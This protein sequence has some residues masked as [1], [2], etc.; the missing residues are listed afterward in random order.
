MED[1]WN[2]RMEV[3]SVIRHREDQVMLSHIPRCKP[4]QGS[5]KC[6]S[7]AYTPTCPLLDSIIDTIRQAGGIPTDEIKGF[8]SV[9]EMDEF[10]LEHL[11]YTQLAYI[12]EDLDNDSTDFSSNFLRYTIVVNST[13]WQCIEME[14]DTCQLDV[15]NGIYS[16][17]KTVMDEHLIHRRTGKSVSLVSRLK[18]TVHPQL[19][20]LDLYAS[21][22]RMMTF[23][24]Y[25]IYSLTILGTLISDKETGIKMYLRLFTMRD[26]PHWIS[27][28]VSSMLA[29]T[30]LTITNFIMN[31][32]FDI[33]MFTKT[34][35][36]ILGIHFFLVSL[37]VST[38][39]FF[40]SVF[41]K[42]TRGGVISGFAVVMLSYI[43]DAIA[44]HLFIDGVD[45]WIRVMFTFYPTVP[46]EHGLYIMATLAADASRDS[47]ITWSE[48][49]DTYSI[50][51]YSLADDWFFILRNSAIFMFLTWY[52]DNVLP[53]GCN[54]RRPFYFP[55]T[56]SYWK[57][58]ASNVPTLEKAT[59][60]PGKR[61]AV[62]TM[63][64][65]DC[66]VI[67]KRFQKKF[68]NFIAV[69]DLCLKVD[70]DEVCCLLGPNGAGKTTAMKSL[71]S[72]DVPTF[73]AAY[74]LGEPVGGIPS[75]QM[76]L[77][78]GYC[79]QFS[80]LYDQLTFFEHLVLYANLKGIKGKAAEEEATK[81]LNDVEL[82]ESRDK[83]AGE[84]S[85]GMQRR[86]QI[87]ISLIG[88]VKFLSL[89]E[90]T[91]GLDVKVRANIWKIINKIRKGRAILLTTHS[92]E[93]TEALQTR[94]AIMAHSRLWALGTSIYLRNAF[95]SGY[96]VLVEVDEE[97]LVDDL[98]E[99]VK[100]ER[101]FC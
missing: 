70:Y 53:S 23:F 88:N 27:M 6:L 10:S 25:L 86:L 81:L 84:G 28:L 48:L 36:L 37:Q 100:D 3:A 35:F 39:I 19:V 97:S 98:V 91:T 32:F 21:A 47:G 101:L 95:G 51:L 20:S 49:G 72:C 15:V 30:I 33:D 46:C 57:G 1:F 41:F 82:S 76:L 8:A 63:E 61:D 2:E 65:H 75:R 74:V 16:T 58:T 50:S 90:P 69:E 34:S 31:T 14:R 89:D 52:L 11:N 96:K 24:V 71:I 79:P 17:A 87:A 13:A 4:S 43:F 92:M 67:I 22:G 77:N 12:F 9:E 64:P 38:F 99:L 83:L 59:H 55:F 40:I 94:I 60:P 68:G 5:D 26:G 29:F 18:R 42:S 73:G 78:I 66:P 56:A 44:V 85:G 93:E 45:R 62:M 54:H 80:C 7:I